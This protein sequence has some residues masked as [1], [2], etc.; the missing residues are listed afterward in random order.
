M[1]SNNAVFNGVSEG[2]NDM[3]AELANFAPMDEWGRQPKPS[4][5]VHHLPTYLI[6]PSGAH[7]SQ[8]CP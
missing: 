6:V 2:F 7:A 1:A 8:T 4:R 3:L 5:A